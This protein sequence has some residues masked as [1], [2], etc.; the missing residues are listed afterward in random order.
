MNSKLVVGS[1]TFVRLYDLAGPD[2]QWPGGTWNVTVYLVDEPVEGVQWPLP[3]TDLL[4]NKGKRCLQALLPKEA[5]LQP[6]QWYRVDATGE[7]DD[8]YRRTF[9]REVQAVRE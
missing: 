2:G 4:D 1:D 6:F 8:G 7:S 9:S 5:R 3:M